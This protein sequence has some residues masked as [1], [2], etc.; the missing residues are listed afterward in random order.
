MRKMLLLMCVVLI[1]S[2]SCKREKPITTTRALVE[3][4]LERY[5]NN[6]YTGLCFEQM[7][8]FYEND[9]LTGERLWLEA[10]QA[11]DKIIIKYDSFSSGSG[12]L[13][14]ADSMYSY[15]NDSLISARKTIHYLLLM[16]LGIYHQPADLTLA[17]LSESGFD[18]AIFR[19]DTYL[20]EKA[21]VIGAQPGDTT[22]NQA[23]FDAENLLFL[24]SVKQSSDGIRR[25]EFHDYVKVEESGYSPRI[26]LFFTNGKL[27]MREEY[28]NIRICDDLSDSVF[29][30]NRF[31]EAW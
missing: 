4:M 12:M 25:V 17:K 13:F 3:T 27:V 20:G 8:M 7:T 21:W 5:S 2:A 16:C 30:P 18:T 10:L 29:D 22:S 19:Q 14:R 1:F 9:S 31:T 23:W 6:W 11:P 24:Y 26:L 28:R 15:E